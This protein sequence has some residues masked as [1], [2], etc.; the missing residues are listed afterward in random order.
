M[1]SLPFP[2]HKRFRQE[3]WTKIL[4]VVPENSSG[5]KKDLRNL[6]WGYYRVEE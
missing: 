2:Y 5:M 3:I 1:I 6:S 4:P